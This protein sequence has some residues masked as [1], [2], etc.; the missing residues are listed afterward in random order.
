MGNLAVKCET[1]WQERKV[2]TSCVGGETVDVR[3]MKADGSGV[4]EFDGPV[5]AAEVM[6]QF[7]DYVVV[8]WCR[9]RYTKLGKRGQLRVLQRHE[10]LTPGEIYILFPIPV[11]VVKSNMI[12]T[13][14][15]SRRMQAAKDRLS[16]LLQRSGMET[17]TSDEALQEEQQ[18]FR[19][20]EKT[21]N[22]DDG[23]SE[24]VEEGHPPPFPG[25]K[26]GGWKSSSSSRDE[27]NEEK[28]TFGTGEEDEQEDEENIMSRKP[29]LF[30][31]PIFPSS[32]WRP[33]LLSIPES[34]IGFHS[35]PGSPMT[36]IAFRLMGS[37]SGREQGQPK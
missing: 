9:K 16:M 35:R 3:V 13:A 31:S 22:N 28:E 2:V 24:E 10:V 8:Q 30:I 17:S 27:T 21:S 14:R 23:R 36:P 15:R 12:T 11:E 1:Q 26:V 4:E 25:F 5:V 20:D 34:P 33:A 18:S 7:P 19:G 37:R 32:S 6:Y 29:D